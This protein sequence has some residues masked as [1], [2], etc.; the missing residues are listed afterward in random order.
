M[1]MVSD[2]STR[3]SE[4]MNG[5]GVTELAIKLGVSKQ[6]VS[7]YL[8]GIRQPKQLAITA[9]AQILCVDP[10]WLMGYDVEKHVHLIETSNEQT[11]KNDDENL[12]EFTS[13]F[14][15]L[16]KEQ[17]SLIT[18]QIKGI[19]SNQNDAESPDEVVRI[20]RA[21]RSDDNRSGEIVQMS[22]KE[23]QE[24]KDAPE[25]DELL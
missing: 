13:L 7:A 16:T 5:M 2:F 17:Q 10:A 14:Q 12:L 1:K 25:T 11:G 21:A 22:K 3:L 23:W 8:K 4:A 24:I 6:S 15:Q 20:Y 9:I 18:S 19:L